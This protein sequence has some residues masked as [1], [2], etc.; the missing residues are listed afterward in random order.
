M[1]S[2]NKMVSRT[3]LE[4]RDDGRCTVIEYKPKTVNHV[5]K[6]VEEAVL[7]DEPCRLSY[8]TV[9]AAEKSGMTSTAD[10]TV[11]LFISPDVVIKPGSKI[12]VTHR[13][14]SL[15]FRS[16]GLPSRYPTHQEIVLEPFRGWT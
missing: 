8:S 11:K 15:E 16:S 6:H 14:V 1:F 10:Q 5:T 9:K 7:S 12:I 3:A 2:E 13:G 4:K